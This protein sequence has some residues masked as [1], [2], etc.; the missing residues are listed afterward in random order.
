M[1][2]RC[3]DTDSRRYADWGGRGIRVHEG[4]HDPAVFIAYLESELGPLPPGHSLDRIDN[5]GDY[6]PGNVRWADAI[7]QRRNRRDQTL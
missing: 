3:Y 5:N 4:W 7:T 6:E 1:M 2:Q